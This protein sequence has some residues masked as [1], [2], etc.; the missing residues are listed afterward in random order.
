MVKNLAIP[1]EGQLVRI[2][3]IGVL[4]GFIEVFLSPVIKNLEPALFGLLMPFVVTILIL[5][6]WKVVPLAGSITI[7]GIIAA[8]MEYFFTGM[9]LTD[10]SGAILLE[11]LGADLILSIGGKRLIPLL[12]VGV[13]VELYSAFHPL[14]FKGNFCHLLIYR[15]WLLDQFQ[16]LG[17]TLSKPQLIGL[18][19]LSHTCMG[20]I[21]GLLFAS[22]ERSKK[23]ISLQEA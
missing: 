11:A 3:G 18:V 2:L 15:K 16:F 10:A 8:V 9:N 22:T 12:L 14:I 6:A 19:I 7:A 21:A 17:P 20:L 5:F 13:Y 23:V 1:I 4:W